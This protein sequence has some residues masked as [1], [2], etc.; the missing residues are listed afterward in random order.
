MSKECT[1][2]CCFECNG[3]GTVW[4][5]CGG[6]YLGQSHSDDLDE[7]ETC[8]SCGGTG[9]EDWCDYCCEQERMYQEEQEQLDAC[10]HCGKRVNG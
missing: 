5:D 9:V 10:E 2:I 3:S 4:F 6:R 8:E 1:C 7:L